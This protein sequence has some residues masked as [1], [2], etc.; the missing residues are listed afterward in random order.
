[1]LVGDFQLL[2]HVA[3]QGC[4]GHSS[5]HS[6]ILLVGELLGSDLLPGSCRLTRT[7]WGECD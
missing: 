6:S 5:C 2:C 3:D 1:L 4:L 7:A